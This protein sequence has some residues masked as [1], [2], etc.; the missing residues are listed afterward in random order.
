MTVGA[1]LS[2]LRSSSLDLVYHHYRQAEAATFLR[3]SRLEFDLTGESEDL[4]DGIDLVLALEE[5]ERLEF[6]LVA[7]AFRAGRAFGD[8]R[9]TWSVGG[10]FAT[11]FAF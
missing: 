7:A 6:E 5:W 4:G 8:E 2:L 3:D 9:G 11:R 1:G 10:F